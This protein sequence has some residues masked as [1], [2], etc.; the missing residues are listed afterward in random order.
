VLSTICDAT[1]KRQQEAIE[2]AGQVDFMVVVGGFES[3]NTRRLAQVAGSAGAAVVHVETAEQ[4]PL[5]E[6]RAFG[7]IGLTAG[8]STPKKIIDRVHSV[9]A[10]L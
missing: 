4:L 3:G 10:S 6:L 9:L 2:L 8:A 5:E 1:M 7:K